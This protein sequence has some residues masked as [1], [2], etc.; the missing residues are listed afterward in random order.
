[1]TLLVQM[2]HERVLFRHTAIRKISHVVTIA[3]AQRNAW[4][5]GASIAEIA[6]RQYGLITTAQLRALGMT[7]SAISR[8]VGSGELHRV[9]PAV[10]AVGHARL[11]TE[12][13]WLA[14]VLAGGRGAAL[15]R[16]AAGR[17]WAC[18][19]FAAPLVDVVAPRFL[20]DRPGVRFH[21]A[22][23]L[24]RRDVTSHRG[25]PVTT[26]HRTPSTSPTS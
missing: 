26:M 7:R 15:N 23:R 13:R 3:P 22:N 24:D 2:R 11:S 5:P 10:Y 8:R 16:L 9:Q 12:A 17:L 20:R 18:S 25:I 21:K 1:V 4:I 14:G 6:G 19:R